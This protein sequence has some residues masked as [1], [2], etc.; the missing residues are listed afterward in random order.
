[1]PTYMHTYI[2]TYIAT[3][4]VALVWSISIDQC[5]YLYKCTY[6]HYYDTYPTLVTVAPTHNHMQCNVA[7]YIWYGLYV[8]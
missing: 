1:M 8:R 7:Y 5:I 4:F 3:T 2:A 6:I